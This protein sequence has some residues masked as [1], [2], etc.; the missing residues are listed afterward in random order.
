MTFE[1]CSSSASFPTDFAFVV[2][3]FSLVS[4]GLVFM[5]CLVFFPFADVLG[6]IRC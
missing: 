1:A 4:L 5:V 3:L 2:R 6:S